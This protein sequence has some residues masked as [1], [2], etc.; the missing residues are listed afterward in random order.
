MAALPRASAEA[1]DTL[2]LAEH[3]ADQAKRAEHDH[4]QEQHAEND[5]PDV[6][7]IVREPEA[8]AFD[9]DG[10]DHRAD[11]RSGSAE[12]NV[13]HDLRR[14]HHAEH[15]GPDES[16]MECIKAAGESGDR[17]ARGKDAGLEMLHLVSEKRDALFV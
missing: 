10:A 15:I 12:Q 7:I 6:A 4:Q 17:S 16:L 13:K 11:Q 8:D 3:E 14:E 5:R 1:A 9:D 2:P